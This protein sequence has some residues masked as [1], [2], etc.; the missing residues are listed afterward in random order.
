MSRAPRGGALTANAPPRYDQDMLRRMFV[1]GIACVASVLLAFTAHAQ[2][3]G[4]KPAYFVFRDVNVTNEF[5]IQL[6]DPSKIAHAR[7]ILAGTE[8]DMVHVAGRIV[9]RPA[10]YNPGWSYHLDPDSIEFFAFAIEVCDANMLYVEEHLDE[11]GGEFLPGNGWCPWSSELVREISV[12]E[13]RRPKL[14]RNR[15]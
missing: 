5:V 7:A 12:R 2:A 8:S 10:S 3:N 13:L 6:R 9:K 14:P 4:R 1:L 11:V 15:R